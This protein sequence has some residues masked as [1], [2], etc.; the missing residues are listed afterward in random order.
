MSTRSSTR[1]SSREGLK[2][3]NSGVPCLSDPTGPPTSSNSC[4]VIGDR[5]LGHF[6]FLLSGRHPVSG[7]GPGTGR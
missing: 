7:V 2:Y 4:S 3:R 1:L 6:Q 5:S